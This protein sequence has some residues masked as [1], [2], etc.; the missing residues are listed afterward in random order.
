[1]P[2]NSGRYTD[3]K[4]L[5]DSFGL[6]AL[7]Y[8]KAT[9]TIDGS[10][11][12]VRFG[13]GFRFSLTQLKQIHKLFTTEA[14]RKAFRIVNCACGAVNKVKLC[15]LCASVVKYFLVFDCQAI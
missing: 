11:L 13:P 7:M 1:M 12:G 8:R 2:K 3:A 15:A 4:S 9:I 14:Q 10:I 5:N 6:V